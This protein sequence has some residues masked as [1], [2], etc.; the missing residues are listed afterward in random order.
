MS[1]KRSGALAT[2]RLLTLTGTGGSGKIRLAL[3]VATGLVSAYPGGI[4]FVAL[5]GLSE[6]ELVQGAVARA[7]GGRDLEL[8]LGSRSQFAA[9]MTEQQG[10]ENTA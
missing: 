2:T 10:A 5:A 6:P 4:W 7:V 8:G 1:S 9:W 3:E